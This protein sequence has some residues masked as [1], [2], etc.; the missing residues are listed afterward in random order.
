MK[1]QNNWLN[2]AVIIPLSFLL[3]AG[4]MVISCQ[5]SST[6]AKSTAET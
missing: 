1:T 3:L 6:S 4:V 5:K 2:K